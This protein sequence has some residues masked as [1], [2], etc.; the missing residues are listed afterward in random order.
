[1]TARARQT[2]RAKSRSPDVTAIECLTSPQTHS[3][4]CIKS[5]HTKTADEKVT[6]RIRPA[7][8]PNPAGLHRLF[9]LI[10][11]LLVDVAR[12]PARQIPTIRGGSEGDVPII[13]EP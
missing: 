2:P 5:T 11:Q 3:K 9:D 7:A 10:A 1:M 8:R 4:M 12:C 6:V 13:V